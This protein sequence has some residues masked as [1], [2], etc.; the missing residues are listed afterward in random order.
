[1]T[2]FELPASNFNF[3]SLTASMTVRTLYSLPLTFAVSW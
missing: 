3:N 2:G 1:M